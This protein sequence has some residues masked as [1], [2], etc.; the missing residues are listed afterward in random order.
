MAQRIINLEE[1]ISIGSDDV[2]FMRSGVQINNWRRVQD[3]GLDNKLTE[4][5]G[6]LFDFSQN[7]T[8]RE[9][10]GIIDNSNL[11]ENL[12]NYTKHRV[13]NCRASWLDESYIGTKNGVKINKNTISDWDFEYLGIQFDLKNSVFPKDFSNYKDSESVINSPEEFIRKM[14]NKSSK[15]VRASGWHKQSNRFFMIYYSTKD[16]NYFDYKNYNSKEN[17]EFL[18]KVNFLARMK[19]ID[20]VF[21]VINK[22]N[23]FELN[24]VRYICGEK[25]MKYDKVYSVICLVGECEN[26]DI[27]VKIIKKL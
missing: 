21:N 8:L 3:D 4:N 25:S 7:G 23:I 27:K 19:A 11:D 15:G 12:K 16:L 9:K 24:D 22:D 1:M 20:K 14:F 17:T 10:F 18:A 26:G 13:L 2:D 5:F 6:N